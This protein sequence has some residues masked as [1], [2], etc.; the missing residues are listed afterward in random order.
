MIRKIFGLISF[1]VS[2]SLFSL[3]ALGSDH[4]SYCVRVYRA[5]NEEIRYG[6]VSPQTRE[7]VLQFFYDKKIP[8][9]NRA[10]KIFA[11]IVSD[12]LN[13]LSKNE[14][15]KVRN[16]L[17]KNIFYDD[18]EPGS[19][20]FAGYFDQEELGNREIVLSLPVDLRDTIVEYTILTHELEHVIQTQVIEREEIGKLRYSTE[21]ITHFV[22]VKY[23]KELGAMLSE[24]E[25]L[26]SIPQEIKQ[27][28]VK[29]V[30][31]H[32]ELY[33]SDTAEF[34]LILLDAPSKTPLEHVQHQHQS[35][36]YDRA[37][38]RESEQQTF[39]FSSLVFITAPTEPLA[40]STISQRLTE[41]KKTCQR[42]REQEKSAPETLGTQKILLHL[43]PSQQ[44]KSN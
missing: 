6:Y 10:R 14:A 20:I 18:Q 27:K 15:K 11:H 29:S 35:G 28:L 34:L 12:R 8:P 38:I 9:K 21:R 16:F 43:C 26:N 1:F 24:F 22:D 42:L 41:I 23:E 17:R 25:Y 3:I 40:L 33:D 30:Q 7:R 13:L 39:W 4:P 32:P 44:H 19:P 31:I 5:L 36:R 37:S 2:W